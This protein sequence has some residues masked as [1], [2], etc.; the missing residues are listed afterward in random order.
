[1]QNLEYA[2]KISFIMRW[3]SEGT[4]S[5]MKKWNG[6]NLVFDLADY[7]GMKVRPLDV[8]CL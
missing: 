8:V 3:N 2:S 7:A 5:Y 6:L 1:M 4:F